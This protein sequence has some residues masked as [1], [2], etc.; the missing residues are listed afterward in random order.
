VFQAAGAAVDRARRGEGPT[1]IEVKTDRYLG[2]FQ[3][4]PEIYR[5]KGE[6]DELRK[7]DPIPLLAGQL[8]RMNLLDEAGEAAVAARVQERVDA[9]FGFAR[10]SPYPEPEDA[11]QHVFV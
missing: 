2:H 1:L 5:P 8:R 3:G 7:S 9:A 11:L 4:D 6:T 10:S